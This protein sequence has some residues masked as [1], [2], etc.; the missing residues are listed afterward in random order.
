MS[1]SRII[2]DGY[3]VAQF[4]RDHLHTD[5]VILVGHSWGAAI[6]IDHGAEPTGSFR[7]LCRHGTD[8]RHCDG[9]TPGTMTGC[10][11]PC[12][13]PATVSRSKPWKGIGP[14]PYDSPEKAQTGRSIAI[15]YVPA[16][17]RNYTW[18]AIR[19]SLSSPDMSWRDL[20]DA[21]KGAQFSAQALLA[22]AGT[23]T[24]GAF[25]LNFQIPMFFI[26]G[27]ADIVTPTPLVEEIRHGHHVTSHRARRHSGRRAQR[28]ADDAER[29]S[30][31]AA[32][33]CATA[34]DCAVLTALSRSAR[35]SRPYGVQA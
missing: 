33:P 27:E 14:P 25:G 18:R 28:D 10:S 20:G 6:G 17:E 30:R 3:E 5:K 11:K 29:I 12:A 9:P 4:L 23:T 34:C 7:G 26:Q 19:G 24:S 1:V 2:E 22:G 15:G 16:S 21:T 31:T 35:S 8:G 32:E 13:P